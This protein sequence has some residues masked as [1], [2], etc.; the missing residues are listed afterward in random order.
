MRRDEPL[1]RH[2]TFR[3][4][5]PAQYFF[6]P[7][8]PDDLRSALGSARQLRLRVRIIGA[9][10]NLLVSD[11]GV[12]GMVIK[13]DTPYF[14]RLRR[15]G[16]FLFAGAGLPVASFLAVCLRQGIGGFEFLS[17]IPG[18]LGG[19]LVMNAGAWGRNIAERVEKVLVMDYNGEVRECP[20]AACGFSYRDSALRDLIVTGALLRAPRRS[21]A[22]I[23]R[24]IEA[25]RKRRAGAQEL[26]RGNAGCVFKNP[27]GRAAGVLIEEAGLKGARCGR[28][29]VSRKH[30]NFIINEGSASSVDVLRLMQRIRRCV[31][32][33][34]G[35]ALEPEIRIWK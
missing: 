25:Y 7:R 5:G 16:G 24:E 32:R 14:R 17:G 1:E 29:A 12:K 27:P 31:K 4:G 33:E 8:D 13:L 22:L 11:R 15:Q 19:A 26:T 20:R 18:T 10:S 23:R 28:A 35:I 30:A 3:I 21:P 9:G 2:T 34:S 6:R